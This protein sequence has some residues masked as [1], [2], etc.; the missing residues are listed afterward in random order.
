MNH[1]GAKG[2]K[3]Y[4]DSNE[5]HIGSLIQRE[6]GEALAWCFL[7]SDTVIASSRS[8]GSCRRMGVLEPPIAGG[9]T[10]ERHADCTDLRGD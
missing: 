8:S 1:E 2:T 9:V 3:K 5:Q 4:E 7:P 6:H 10:D